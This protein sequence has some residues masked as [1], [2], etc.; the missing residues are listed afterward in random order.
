MVLVW[1]IR[2]DGDSEEVDKAKWL[3]KDIGE[4]GTQIMVPSL[5]VSEYLSG[6]PED[7]HKDA[8]VS[9]GGLK[10]TNAGRVKTGQ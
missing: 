3:F 5:V 4:S 2:Q 7:A 1:G 10:S 8:L 6:I 9:P